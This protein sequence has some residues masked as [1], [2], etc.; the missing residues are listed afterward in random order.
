MIM[1]RFALLSLAAVAAAMLLASCGGFFPAADQIVSLALSPTGAY[2]LQTG[3][4]QFTATATF[5]NN[6]TG[7]VTSQ[8]A[9]SSSATNIATINSS[10]L[11][12]AVA[13]GTTTITAKS[14]NSSVTSTAMLTV[15]SKTVTTITVSP[16]NP[17]LLLAGGQSQQFTASATFSDGTIGDVTSSCAWTSSNASVATISSSGLAQPV[18]TGST[19]IGASLGGVAGTTTLTIQ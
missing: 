1:R 2:I 4:Q 18:S 17:T 11:A 7:D 14:N 19:V 5:G 15:S 10:G 13:L 8:V 12:T 9:W 6:T 3:T 16:A